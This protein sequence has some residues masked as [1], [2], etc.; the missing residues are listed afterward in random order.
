MHLG[1]IY[2]ASV[3]ASVESGSASRLACLRDDRLSQRDWYRLDFFRFFF[4]G[5]VLLFFFFYWF[6]VGLLELTNQRTC[7]KVFS[8]GSFLQ[9]D[10]GFATIPACFPEKFRPT[11]RSTSCDTILIANKAQTLQYII[12]VKCEFVE[13]VIVQQKIFCRMCYSLIEINW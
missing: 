12:G 2:S 13:N 9:D 4:P 7:L 1:N 3:S 8:P 5:H 6:A 10:R 11:I